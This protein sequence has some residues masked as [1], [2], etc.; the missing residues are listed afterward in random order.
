MSLS[1]IICGRR[2]WALQTARIGDVHIC[3]RVSGEGDPLLLI[4]G[5]TASMEEWNPH[6]IEALSRKYRVLTFDNRGAG[7]TEAPP[8][9]FSMKLFADDTAGL[10]AALG[11]DGAIVL[12]ESMGGMIAQELALNHADL[13]KKLILCCTFCG[14]EEAVF[15]S[16]EVIEEMSDREGT[17]EE[18]VRRGLHLLF[19][20]DWISGHPD[21]VESVVE[22]ATRFPVAEDNAERQFTA[23]L[24]HS[25]Y[26]RLSHIACPTLVCCGSDDVIIPPENSRILASRIPLAEE[27]VFQGAGHGFIEQCGETFTKRLMRF[28]EET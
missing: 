5:F 6:F 18:I 24:G 21:K 12:G 27:I 2:R 7:R 14:G 23:I 13:V 11:I 4:R 9:E 25:T 10:M 17:P 20:E 19:P 1:C 15:P 26:Q 28:I 22:R 3:Y 8:G 16:V